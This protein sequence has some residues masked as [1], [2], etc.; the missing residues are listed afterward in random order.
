MLK[1]YYVREIVGEQLEITEIFIEIRKMSVFGENYHISH[2][3]EALETILKKFRYSDL[4]RHR[5][6]YSHFHVCFFISFF[7]NI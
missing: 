6:I 1:Y 4:C 5:E 2:G 3:D 7:T